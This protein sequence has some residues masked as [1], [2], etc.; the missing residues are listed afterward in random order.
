MPV[1]KQRSALSL[2]RLP[3][4]WRPRS[5]APHAGCARHV[6]IDGRAKP[7]RV[8]ARVKGARRNSQPKSAGLQMQQSPNISYVPNACERRD[9]SYGVRAAAP[10]TDMVRW[11]QAAR[12]NRFGVT[13]CGP[14]QYNPERCH[15]LR[16]GRCP[17]THYGAESTARAAPPAR[18]SKAGRAAATKDHTPNLLSRS[19]EI[20]H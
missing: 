20:L 4:G 6:L 9:H 1:Q 16:G 11:R 17:L 13:Q 3:S 5:H 2:E 14:N 15:A 19:I 12:P 18:A 8:C 10:I 7:I